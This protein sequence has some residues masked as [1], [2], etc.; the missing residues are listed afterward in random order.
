MPFLSVREAGVQVGLSTILPPLVGGILHGLSQLKLSLGGAWNRSS[1]KYW[2]KLG[3]Q[4]LT[5]S[6]LDDVSYRSLH[7]N[8]GSAVAMGQY[9]PYNP[10]I[11]WGTPVGLTEAL[12]IQPS[13]CQ[14]GARTLGTAQIVPNFVQELGPEAIVWWE[15][16][17]L[18]E[19]EHIY[20]Y[21]TG[22][23]STTATRITSM[24]IERI[25]DNPF[26]KAKTTEI[27]LPRDNL[28]KPRPR[29]PRGP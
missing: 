22:F 27:W 5:E 20:F 23:E 16:K 15:M 10:N 6:P 28:F 13:A 3:S 14:L 26:L 29:T 11:G 4:L 9:G 2:E 21:Y 19:A 18:Y 17:Y 12:A 8:P 24:E 25:Y 7:L 1:A